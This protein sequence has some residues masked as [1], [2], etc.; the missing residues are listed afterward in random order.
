MKGQLIKKK[1]KYVII[2]INSSLILIINLLI[3]LKSWL[4]SL[5]FIYLIIKS[6]LTKTISIARKHHILILL[7]LHHDSLSVFINSFLKFFTQRVRSNSHATYEINSLGVKL[8]VLFKFIKINHSTEASIH[9][10]CRLLRKKKTF[11]ENS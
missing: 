5:I 4:L 8:A 6:N 11:F 2:E 3:L 1:K 10:I 9:F 7:L